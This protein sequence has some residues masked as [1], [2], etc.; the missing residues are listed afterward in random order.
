MLCTCGGTWRTMTVNNS[1]RIW[2]IICHS[3]A[4]FT[5]FSHPFIGTGLGIALLHAVAKVS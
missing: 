5:L 3:N 1:H 2:D 4:I